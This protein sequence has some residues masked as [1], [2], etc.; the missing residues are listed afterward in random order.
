MHICII[1]LA[2]SESL[3]EVKELY[4]TGRDGNMEPVHSVHVLANGTMKSIGHLMA[5]SVCNFGP[6]PNFMQK[7]IYYY[8]VGGIEKVL[9]NLPSSLEDDSERHYLCDIFNKVNS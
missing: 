5:A 2:F 3:K 4:F 8:I 7:W 9:E 1:F 6:A